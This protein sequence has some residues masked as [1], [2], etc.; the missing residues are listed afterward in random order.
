[1]TIWHNVLEHSKDEWSGKSVEAKSDMIRMF[2]FGQQVA[3]RCVNMDSASDEITRMFLDIL[4]NDN[5]VV[6]PEWELPIERSV[7]HVNTN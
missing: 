6:T 2:L 3:L 5:W 1:M 7:D 4:T